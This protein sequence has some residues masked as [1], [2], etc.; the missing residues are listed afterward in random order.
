MVMPME[1]WGKDQAADQS[2]FS[3]PSTFLRNRHFRVTR[4]KRISNLYI[5]FA[6]RSCLA[7]HSKKV[8]SR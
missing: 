3:S 7:T 2:S 6:P 1:R 4:S 8:L 5:A